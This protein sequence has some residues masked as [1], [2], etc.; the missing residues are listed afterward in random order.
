MESQLEEFLRSLEHERRASANTVRAYERDITQLVEF[1]R[2]KS[3]RAPTVADLDIP[4]VRAYLA[5][6]FGRCSASTIARKLSSLRSFGAFLVRRGLREDNPVRLVKMP[7]Q[8]R[9]LPRFLSEEEAAAVMAAPDPDG[10]LGARDRAILELLYG[11]GLRVSEVCGLDIGD[12]DLMEATLTVR[13]GKGSKDRIVPAGELAVDATRSYLDQRPSLRHPRTG[14]Q[15]PLALFLNYRG[16]RLTV[17]SVARMVDR[18]CLGAA[19]RSR[20]GPHALRHSCATHMLSSGADLRAIQEMLG[21]ASLQTTQRYTHVSIDHLMRV[22]DDAHPRA[23]K[24]KT[25]E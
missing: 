4:Q 23:T 10:A 8:V 12:V 2:E 5:S 18:S 22:Y 20:V 21:H 1:L 16:G 19:T 6:L 25:D 3:G 24:G 13:A 17:R 15:D 14:Y 7:R 11:S 9:T